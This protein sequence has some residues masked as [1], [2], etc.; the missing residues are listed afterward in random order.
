MSGHGGFRKGAGR[1][2]SCPPDLADQAMQYLCVCVGAPS[3]AG[4]CRFAAINPKSLSRWQL[5]HDAVANAVGVIRNRRE[6]ALGL[7]A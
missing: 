7:A 3:M 6:V 5:K 1:P 4:F 2:S